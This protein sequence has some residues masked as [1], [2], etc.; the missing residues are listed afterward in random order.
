MRRREI[1]PRA[2]YAALCRDT[3]ATPRPPPRPLTCPS[4]RARS[5]PPPSAKSPPPAPPPPCASPRL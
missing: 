3:P 2:R 4:P 5:P 1:A